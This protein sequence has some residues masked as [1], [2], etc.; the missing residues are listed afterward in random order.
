M[1]SSSSR[2]RREHTPSPSEGEGSFG[3]AQGK[4]HEVKERPV[5]PLQDPWYTPSLFFPQVSHGEA[6]SSPYTWVFSGQSGFACSAQ[7]PDLREILDLQIRR[8]S[9]EVAPIFF[10]FVLGKITDW[11]I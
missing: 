7:V 2:K 4:T 3:S 1:A 9:R 8:G 6:P 5:F 10:D 11:P